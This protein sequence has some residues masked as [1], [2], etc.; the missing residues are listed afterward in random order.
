MSGS[1][2]DPPAEALHNAILRVTD[3]HGARHHPHPLTSQYILRGEPGAKYTMASDE[4]LR[5]MQVRLKQG[6]DLHDSVHA[7]VFGDGKYAPSVTS[8]YWH[9]YRGRD[10]PRFETDDRQLELQTALN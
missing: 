3:G 6:K 2:P 4:F 9:E 8:K 7:I 10:I 1:S 5:Q